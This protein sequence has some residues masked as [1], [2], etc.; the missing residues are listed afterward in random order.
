M[1]EMT[2]CRR[3]ELNFRPLP[4]QGSALPLSY[5]GAGGTLPQRTQ[6]GNGMLSEKKF[7]WKGS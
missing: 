7:A 3:E 5:G 2:W 4:Y 6:A 1:L